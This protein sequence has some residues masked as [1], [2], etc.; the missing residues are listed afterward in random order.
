[1][2]LLTEVVHPHLHLGL[3]AGIVV[4]R[5]VG[6]GEHEARRGHPAGHMRLS[7]GVGAVGGIAHQ[8]RVR[9]GRRPQSIIY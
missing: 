4:L 8:E 9:N 1:M 6:G 2:M 7:Q 5:P 3:D